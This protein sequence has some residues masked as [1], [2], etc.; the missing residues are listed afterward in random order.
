MQ[1]FQMMNQSATVEEVSDAEITTTIDRH[2]MTQKGVSAH[3][4]DVITHEGVVRLAGI[5]DNLLSRERAE[6]IALAVRGVRSVINELV[7]STPDVAD[8][9]LKR[10]VSSALADDPATT[11]YPLHCTANDGVVTL[12]G[13]LQ[14]WAE[15][16]LALRVVRGVR[17]VRSI[18]ADEVAIEWGSQHNSDQEIT[19]Q[20]RELLD[21]DI[22]VYSALVE[23]DTTNRLTHLAGTVGT[24]AEKAHVITTAYQAGATRVD[25]RDL[26]VAA[27]ALTRELRQEKHAARSDAAIATAVLDTFRFDA[28]VRAT[29]PL[30]VV[31][32][33]VVTLTGNVGNLRAKQAA[34]RDARHV[35]GVW[36]VHNLLKVRTS[37]FMPDAN[38]SQTIQ[39]ALARDPYLS[40]CEFSVRVHNGKALLFGHVGSHFEQERAGGV[41]AGVNGVAEVENWVS[42]PANRTFDGFQA[43]AWSGTTLRPKSLNP[44]FALA[45]R[46]RQRYFW[47]ASLHNQD[48]EVSVQKGRVTLTGTVDTWPDHQQAS[49]DAYAAG[50]RDVD[51]E[52]HVSSSF[53][54]L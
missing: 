31:R 18:A 28:R 53:G 25:A 33:G 44:D 11:D 24:A 39:D 2:Y 40:V 16:E 1:T 8:D 6:E 26:N 37:R 21:W 38:V 12:T 3:L 47:S 5:T 46:I 50:A 32:H 17:G 4:I 13:T 43:Y 54:G 10:H 41:A 15:K 34:E 9:Q 45:E 30:V 19:T 29:T 48:V 51:N 7:I 20:V 35:V 22:R 42:V 14:S 23:I 49:V 27:W 36:D 52:L